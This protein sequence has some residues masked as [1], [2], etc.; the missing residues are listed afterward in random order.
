MTTTTGTAAGSPVPDLP[1][2]EVAAG[3][4][5]VDAVR[6][7]GTAVTELARP[8]VA[9]AVLGEL[10]SLAGEL[11]RVAAGRSSIAP[12]RG[13]RRF[14]DRTWQTNPVYRRLMQAYLAESEALTRV[15]GLMG[16]P[17]QARAQAEFAASLVADAVAP[18]NTLL[19]NPAALK[20]A[21]ATRGR[22]L[23]RGSRHLV[24]DLVHNG[25]MP[26]QVDHKAF[27]VGENLAV[28][29]GAVVYRSEVLELIQYQPTTARVHTKPLLLIPPQINKFYVMDLVPDRSFIE[30]AVAHGIQ[31]FAV[32]WRNP[33]REQRQ[34]NLDTYVA[35]LLEAVDVAGDITGSED[36]NTIGLCAGGITMASMLGH[37]AATGDDRVN[38]AMFAVTL[39]DPSCQTIVSPFVNAATLAAAKQSSRLRGVLR[40]RDTARIF[41][42]FRANDLVWNYWVRN[43]LLGEDPPAFDLL[44]WN[45][46]F[47]NLPAGLHADFLDIVRDNPFARPGVLRVLGTP[48]D[49]RQFTGDAYVL[50]GL[51]DHL[52][53][54][55]ACYRTTQL[56]GG[57]TEFALTNSGHV[58]SLINPPG[59]A[60]ASY[61]VGP[62][63]GPDPE[64]WRAAAEERTGTAWEHMVAWLRDRSGP[65]RN[66]PRK[67]GNRRHPATDPTP[68]QYALTQA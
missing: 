15:P 11:A 12:Q 21:G 61:R 57:R 3:T 5:P 1:W 64:A 32:S 25:G 35:A 7:L 47:T 31:L 38:A 44:Y 49:L 29:P 63:P 41:T 16:L 40:G 22:S 37:L 59:N 51:T 48:I 9:G 60:K 10:A 58:Q 30:Y 6:S 67:T 24:D 46:D 19:G 55:Q 66:A 23:L 18:T 4:S 8:R 33:T 28:S 53:P 14:T 52:T 17:A 56:V 45:N 54:W 2:G 13:D 50:G 27:R 65:E 36:V 42:W 43:Y 62:A 26:A 68:G 39:L 20:R 34:W